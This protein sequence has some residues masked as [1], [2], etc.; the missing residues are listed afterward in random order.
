MITSTQNLTKLQIRYIQD[1]VKLCN[2]KSFMW[3]YTLSPS[4]VN[5]D[6]KYNVSYSLNGE[7]Y[8][9]LM[10]YISN[11]SLFYPELIKKRKINIFEKIKRFFLHQS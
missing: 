9:K 11:S 6:I 10:E 1:I 3:N 2:L 4:Y 8:T 7:D 5:N